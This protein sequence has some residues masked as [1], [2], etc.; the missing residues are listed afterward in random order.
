[1]KKN[2]PKFIYPQTISIANGDIVKFFSRES[3]GFQGFGEVYFSKI[4]S[5]KIKGWK[6]HHRVTCNLMVIHGIVRVV[7]FSDLLNK[8]TCLDTN[9]FADSPTIIQIPPMNWFAFQGLSDKTSILVN[10][11]EELH[12]PNEMEKKDLNFFEYDWSTK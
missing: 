10:L 9:F 6:R 5:N 4:K 8:K 12:D 1:M 7:A 3:P 11:I 2:N